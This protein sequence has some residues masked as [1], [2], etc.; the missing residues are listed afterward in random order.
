[1][2]TWL[3]SLSMYSGTPLKNTSLRKTLKKSQLHE[4]VSL[5]SGVSFKRVFRS[6]HYVFQT[7]IRIWDVYYSKEC[8]VMVL[9][10]HVSSSSKQSSHYEH[11][12]LLELI[13]TDHKVSQ[14][15]GVAVSR[16]RIPI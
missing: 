2:L 11:A 16:I 5:M 12:T 8:C 7:Y 4:M 15:N 6:S 14:D 3:I 1:M 13:R 10:A 9:Y